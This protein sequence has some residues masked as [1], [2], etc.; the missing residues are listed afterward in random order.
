MRRSIALTEMVG[1][2]DEPPKRNLDR[3]KKIQMMTIRQHQPEDLDLE[4]MSAQDVIDLGHVVTQD[5]EGVEG[6]THLKRKDDPGQ[7]KEKMNIDHQKRRG[8][9]MT[10]L[11]HHSMKKTTPRTDLPSN[12]NRW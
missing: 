1:E 3:L 6:T 5:Q 11:H 9:E 8:G 2:K 10:L 12:L 4:G 7:K